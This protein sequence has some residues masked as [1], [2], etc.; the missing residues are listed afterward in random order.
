M[1]DKQRG[2]LPPEEQSVSRAG[3]DRMVDSNAEWVWAAVRRDPDLFLLVWLRLADRWPATGSDS[4]DSLLQ[5]VLAGL[6]RGS[7]RPG[8][9]PTD[10]PLR[11]SGG[12]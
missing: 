11:A 10:E 7:A 9:S 3:W 4:A 1:D 8:T 12:R 5:G 2:P 6:D